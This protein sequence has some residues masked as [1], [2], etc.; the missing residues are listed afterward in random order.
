MKNCDYSHYIHCR[1]NWLCAFFPYETFHLQGS[2]G[3]WCREFYQAIQHT[4]ANLH[5]DHKNIKRKSFPYSQFS[6]L[7][8]NMLVCRGVAPEIP[9]CVFGCLEPNRFQ[10][11]MLLKAHFV[12]YFHKTNAGEITTLNSVFK[13]LHIVFLI[14]WMTKLV[15]CCLF[16]CSH[17]FLFQSKCFFSLSS[18][19][20]CSFFSSLLIVSFA[21]L[22]HAALNCVS[23]NSF[24]HFGRTFSV[25]IFVRV[26]DSLWHS[27]TRNIATSKMLADTSLSPF[28]S[29][30]LNSTF[31]FFFSCFLII[32]P[33]FEIT[34]V[35]LANKCR[36]AFIL[37]DIQMYAFPPL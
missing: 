2:F 22:N 3:F 1:C 29:H 25:H 11:E 16:F 12:A 18:F 33:L 36:S 26:L 23:F 8:F 7:Y 37:G 17:T 34:G 20:C 28:S 9:C 5:M 13:E 6:T 14:T 21:L 31:N 30:I 35:K 15:S 27:D 24:F 32:S 19:W 4:T 10:F